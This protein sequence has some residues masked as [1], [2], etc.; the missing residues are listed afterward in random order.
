MNFSAPLDNLFNPDIP[1][2]QPEEPTLYDVMMQ[3]IDTAMMDM[4]TWI[5]ASIHAIKFSPGLRIDIQPLLQARYINDPT[6]LNNNGGY[7]ANLPVISDVMVCMPQGSKYGVKFPLSVGDTG[8]A[9][10][11]ERSLDKWAVGSG[12]IVDPQDTRKHNI[13]DPIFIPGLVPFSQ[14]TTDASEAL[15]LTAPNFRIQNSTTELIENLVNLVETLAGSSTVAGGPFIP[16]VVS[17]LNAITANLQ[18]L[19]G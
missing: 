15:T 5:P 16:S 1:T 9:L 10:F 13:S 11:C 6:N 3:A 8:I 17:A 2:Y 14:A 4:H 7:V 18:S 12:A 19:Q